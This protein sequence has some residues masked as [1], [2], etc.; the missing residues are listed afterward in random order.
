MRLALAAILAVGV[1]AATEPKAR[2]RRL[3]V[4]DDVVPPLTLD[5]AK[6]FSEKN[7]T[8]VQQIFEGLV[9]FDP[10]G[11]IEPALAVSWTRID[12]LT[13]EFKL[14]ENVRFHNGEPFDAESVRISIERLMDPKRFPAAGFL[15]SIE[16]VESA[17]SSRV[18][19]KTKFPDGL[20]LHRLA[21]FVTIVPPKYLSERGEERLAVQPIGTGP[22]RFVRAEPGRIVL[23]A[24]PEHWAKRVQR[25]DVLEFLFLPVEGQVDGLLDGE[26]DIVTELPGTQTL[27]VMRSRHAMIVKKES[28][29][30]PASSWNCKSGPLAD[31]RVRR[32]INLAVNR[33]QLV[34][35]DLLGNGRP[36]ATLTMPGELGHA[37]DLRPYPFDFAEA[38][39]LLKEAGHEKGFSLKALVKVQGMRT[40]KIIERQIARLGIRVDITPTTDGAAMADM[41]KA[42]W[43]WIFAGCPDPLSHSF[44]VQ[45][46]FLS[47][48]SPFSVTKDARYDEL[49]ASMV[50]ALDPGEQE[51]RGRE[52]DHYM[53]DQALS[54]FTYQRIK[55]YG[56]RQGVHFTPSITGM[57]YFD[58]SY[59]EDAAEK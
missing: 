58:L 39:R 33:E 47:S 42:S 26:V 23:A 7:H 1:A 46:I 2:G 18:R 4:C 13:V 21:G 43:D 34:R 53:Y 10:E 28:F 11:R 48:L 6:E 15:S 29:Y 41:Q 45:F 16:R 52:I 57:P 22:F 59:P 27:R 14:R 24:N 35:Y 25:F 55:T 50:A 56:V 51:R 12:P 20:L 37:S 36:L 32:A 17:G 44:F 54:L 40:F 5:P 19:I 30:T 31:V 3:R 38:R 9:R 49:L 8:I